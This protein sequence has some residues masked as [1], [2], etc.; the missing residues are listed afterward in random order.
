SDF[1]LLN[2]SGATFALTSVAL[3]SGLTFLDVSSASATQVAA[4]T[5]A[6]G[7]GVTVNPGNE[8]IVKD[9]VAT[10]TSASTFK[11]IAGFSDPGVLSTITLP[12]PNTSLSF[13]S[14]STLFS[15]LVQP[16]NGL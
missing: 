6:A 13:T 11:N 7:A 2:D 14:G 15:P 5:T 4:L 16:S 10:T 3:G 9:S 8:I 1:G 12:S